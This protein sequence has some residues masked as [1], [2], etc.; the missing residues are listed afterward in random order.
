[1]QVN[2]KRQ[3]KNG[4]WGQVGSARTQT[5][6]KYSVGGTKNKAKYQAIAQQTTLSSGDV[7]LKASSPKFKRGG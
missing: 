2:L 6:G 5:N 4:G 1:V 3:K 7:C